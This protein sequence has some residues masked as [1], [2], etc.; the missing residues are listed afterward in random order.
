MS[1][2]KKSLFFIDDDEVYLYLL[3]R[4]CKKIDRVS[5]IFTA[6]DGLDAISKLEKW[7]ETAQPLPDVMFIDINM[8]RLN[9]FGFLEKFNQMKEIHKELETIRPV[10]LLT[11]SNEQRDRDQAKELGVCNYLV[12]PDD[13]QQARQAIVEVLG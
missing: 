8:P 4:A 6:Y 2:S 11:S 7:L 12:K 5:Q 1:D 3:E 13:L 10:I 9:G